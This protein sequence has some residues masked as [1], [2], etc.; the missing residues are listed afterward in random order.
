MTLKEG[1]FVRKVAAP[2]KLVVTSYKHA[3][4]LA[5][6]LGLEPHGANLYFLPYFLGLCVPAQNLSLI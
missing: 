2:T 3:R 6:P 5:N 1:M 4:T